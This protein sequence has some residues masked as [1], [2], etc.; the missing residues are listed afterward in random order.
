MVDTR[1]HRF[2]GPVAIGALLTE[3]G[4][5]E[6]AADLTNANSIVGGVSELELAAADEL[7]RRSG[8]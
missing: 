5:P 2:A 6:L 4:F 3:L 1:F 7:V 8:R